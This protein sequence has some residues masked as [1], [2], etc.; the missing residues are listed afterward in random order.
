MGDK[1]EKSVHIGCAVREHEAE[2]YVRDTGLG[3]EPED[4]ERVFHIFRRGR[5]QS[6]QNVAGKGVGLS[7]VKSIIETYGGTIWVESQ[8]GQGSVFRFT[9]SEEFL[10]RDGAVRPEP[11]RSAAGLAGCEV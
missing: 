5:G 4:V 2:F 6:V 7:S 8:V 9:I 10:Q 11:T 3:I 1:P